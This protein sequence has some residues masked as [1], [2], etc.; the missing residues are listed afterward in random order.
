[1]KS[2]TDFVIDALIEFEEILRTFFSATGDT[3]AALINSTRDRL[4]G[5]LIQD[6][7]TVRRI[8]NSL[9]HRERQ[10]LE[11][12]DEFEK[13]YARINECLLWSAAPSGALVCSRVINKATG[14]CIDVGWDRSDGALYQ[15]EIHGG[16]NQRWV[17]RQTSDGYYVI[18]SWYSLKCLD[19]CG[20]SHEEGASIVLWNYWNGQNQ[21]WSIHQLDDGSYMIRA[22]HSGYVLDL[23]GGTTENG[24][25]LMQWNWHG[26][27]S[28]RWWIAPAI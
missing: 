25:H 11:S 18:Q 21:L 1:M 7:H 9:A 6:L 12:R 26:G 16:V 2:D 22:R 24:P 5:S 14:K 23:A 13:L 27:D 20:F 3:S 17:L 15:C 4:P 28:Q 19:V 8:R 10:H